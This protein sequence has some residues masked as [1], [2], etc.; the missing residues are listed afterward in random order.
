ML[1]ES[2]LTVIIPFEIQP[3]KNSFTNYH[4]CLISCQLNFA[5]VMKNDILIEET[6]EC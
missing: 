2:L 4:Y 1:E 6:G 3:F 5:G